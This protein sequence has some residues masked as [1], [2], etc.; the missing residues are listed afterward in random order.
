MLT[1]SH[2][3]VL[4]WGQLS[5]MEEVKMKNKRMGFTLIELLVVIA[6]IAILA[7]IL[8]P[9]F[10][11]AKAAAFDTVCINNLKQCGLAL[12]MYNADN[13]AR[14]PL[15]GIPSGAV[16]GGFIYVCQKYT[17]TKLLAKCPMDPTPQKKFPVSYW[18]NSYLNYWSGGGPGSYAPPT[19]S[20]VRFA[21]TT[22]FMMDGPF[23]AIGISGRLLHNMY[24]PPN[25]WSAAGSPY[26]ALYNLYGGYDKCVKEAVTRH[27]GAAN[28]LF[29]DTHVAKVRP[30]G[31]QTDS[32]VDTGNPIAEVM[33]SMPG[34]KWRFRNDGH[35]PWF[36]FN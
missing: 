12:T 36:R 19:E 9:V 13:G 21:K 17:K 27:G 33:G 14:Y 4:G 26:E 28:V 11:K 34:G 3:T 23:G 20:Q 7:A 10:V 30:N 5:V 16:G 25:E 32:T 1:R 15:Y 31:W 35:H 18:L 6:I 2:R 24:C 22:C 8:F 29:C